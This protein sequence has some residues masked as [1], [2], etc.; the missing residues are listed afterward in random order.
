MG[1]NI[2]CSKK[3]KLSTRKRQNNFF[4][5]M[6]AKSFL[7]YCIIVRVCTQGLT[8]HWIVT[9]NVAFSS[10]SRYCL[11]K[12]NGIRATHE[13]R[14]MTQSLLIMPPYIRYSPRKSIKGCGM[15]SE[16]MARYSQS[17]DRRGMG[18]LEFLLITDAS[19]MPIIMCKEVVCLIACELVSFI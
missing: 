18:S 14:I 19:D 13:P 4:L 16:T 11:S 15:K 8:F 17:Y 2:Q 7:H 9:K 10:S 12:R 3:K 5:S 1:P 6:W